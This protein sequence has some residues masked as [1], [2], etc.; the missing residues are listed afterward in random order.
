MRIHKFDSKTPEISKLHQPLVHHYQ[1]GA[2][3]RLFNEYSSEL[4]KTIF[5]DI[6]FGKTCC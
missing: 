2:S 6:V 5:K 4:Q 3:K 1:E